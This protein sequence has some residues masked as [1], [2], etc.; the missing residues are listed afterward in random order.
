MA[1]NQAMTE[2]VN[3]KLD[4]YVKSCLS[5]FLYNIRMQ[6]LY[7][8]AH[9]SIRLNCGNNLSSWWQLFYDLGKQIL[10]L[11]NWAFQLKRVI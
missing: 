9:L 1:R 8:T 7:A 4:L 6:Y 2:V 3:I 10:N 11:L 5:F